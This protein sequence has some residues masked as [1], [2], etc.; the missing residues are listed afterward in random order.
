M[1]DISAA[2]APANLLTPT[3]APTA[4]DLAKRGDIHKTAQ[5]FEASFLSIM[6][7]QM[8]EGVETSAP[9]GGG[10][11]E[12]MFRSFMT[13]AIAK[14]MAESGGVGIAALLSSWFGGSTG[15]LHLA[16]SSSVVVESGDTLWSI[17]TSIAG[18]GD[19]RTT[20]DEIRQLNHLTSADIAPGQVLELP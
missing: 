14:Q 15:G 19:V 12:T 8:F 11:G 3:T 6:L 20:I 17:A 1:T 7:Q 5:K 13:D 2:I 9:F 10:S 18:D 4:A 16:G